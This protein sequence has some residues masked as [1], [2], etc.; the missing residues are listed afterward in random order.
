MKP[1][2][3]KLSGRDLPL[4]GTFND[5]TLAAN[6]TIKEKVR[7]NCMIRISTSFRESLSHLERFAAQAVADSREDFVRDR[8]EEIRQEIIEETPVR[9][10][11]GQAG[12]REA[13]IETE[14]G[15]STSTIS[16]LSNP[17]EYLVYL[18]YGTRRMRAREIIQRVLQRYSEG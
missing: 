8:I 13:V 11:R 12:W 17:V 14:P 7:A 3:Q 5:E 6:R 10:G 15:S 2:V 4:R 1:L 9:T 16:S 18:E